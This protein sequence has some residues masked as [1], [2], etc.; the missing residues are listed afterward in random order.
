[1]YLVR[2][3]CSQ[4]VTVEVSMHGQLEAVSI[5]GLSHTKSEK[6]TA[7]MKAKKKAGV[8]RYDKLEE[9][10]QLSYYSADELEGMTKAQLVGLVSADMGVTAR[11][12][13]QEIL[14]I[15][16]QYDIPKP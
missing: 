10:P 16:N 14:A 4:G 1:M 9:K 3:L 6:I 15:L 2:S 5:R 11:Q 8:I 13:K 12:T 7:D